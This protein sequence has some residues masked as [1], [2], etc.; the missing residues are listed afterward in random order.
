[1]PGF[2]VADGNPAPV[3]DLEVWSPPAP[4][5][6]PPPRGGSGPAW[7]AQSAPR[8]D[9]RPVA[10][11]AR[12]QARPPLDFRFSM[13]ADRRAPRGQQGQA[14][15]R[16]RRAGVREGRRRRLPQDRQGGADPRIPARQGSP[17]HPGGSPGQGDRAQRG[18]AATPCPT[19]TRRPS[20]STTSTPS[21]RPRSTSPRVRKPGRWPSTQSWRS[22][23]SCI[24]PATTACG[25]RSPARW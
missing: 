10:G 17:P 2:E 3:N 12:R 20:A 21:P 6:G 13:R 18:A 16:G 4:V 15:H 24:W 19:T 5:M 7:L 25:S 1:M 9:P 14:E 11:Q 22:D 8:V 23:P